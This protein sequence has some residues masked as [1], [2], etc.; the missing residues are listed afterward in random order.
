MIKYNNLEGI[1]KIKLFQNAEL[2][3]W[4]S[5]LDRW[6]LTKKRGKIEQ[7]FLQHDVRGPSSNPKLSGPREK[8][9]VSL[10]CSCK[11]HVLEFSKYVKIERERER[12]RESTIKLLLFSS[13]TGYKWA[14]SENLSGG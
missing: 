2:Y 14:K 3:E 12:E 11:S 9:L 6:P 13:W 7:F 10:A 5:A 1:C 4:D 8:L